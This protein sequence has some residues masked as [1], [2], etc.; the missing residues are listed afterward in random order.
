[1]QR[2]VA[3]FAHG[4]EGSPHGRKI[5]ALARIARRRGFEIVVPDYRKI[6]DPEERVRLLCES[7]PSASEHLVFVGS[8][9]G[10]YVSLAASEIHTPQGI[11]VLAPAV[12]IEGF[13][14]SDL[15]PRGETIWAVHGWHDEIV[16]VDRVIA[17]CRRFSIPLF[18]LD[19]D[20]RLLDQLPR[21]ERLFDL[22]LSE[23]LGGK[24]QEC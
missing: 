15:A 24:G 6:H 14:R 3:Y 22:F 20:H 23:V 21:I 16:P 10:G 2:N 7:K 17:F 11:F 13:G 4:L 9:L 19:G 8:S 1:M 12:G 5:R 18:L